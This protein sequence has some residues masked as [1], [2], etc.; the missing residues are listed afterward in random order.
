MTTLEARLE[1]VERA[2]AA[3][4]GAIVDLRRDLADFRM[5]ASRR[6]DAIDQRFERIDQR[7]DTLTEKMTS[8][9]CWMTVL[10]VMIFSVMLTA[11]V[12]LATTMA[13]M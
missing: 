13:A 3:H 10:M 5:A 11:Y 12:A 9:F 8:G 7:F 4:E 2:M 6:F 1:E